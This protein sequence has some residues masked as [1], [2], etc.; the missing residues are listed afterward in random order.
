MCGNYGLQTHVQICF[1]D[2]CFATPSNE[3]H[4]NKYSR[5]QVDL[6][7]SSFDVRDFV[8]PPFANANPPTRPPARVL[9]TLSRFCSQL[10]CCSDAVG[11]LRGGAPLIFF[12]ELLSSR[13]ALLCVSLSLS[14]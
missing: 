4:Q 11:V 9:G 6:R 3:T 12:D 5:T 8:P 13:P 2:P 14:L 1:V 10:W 7:S